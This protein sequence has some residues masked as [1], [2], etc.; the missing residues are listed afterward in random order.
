MAVDIGPKI[1][2]DGEAEFRREI[3]NITQQIKTFGSELNAVTAEFGANERSVQG[4]TAKNEILNKSI[5]AQERKVRE[6]KKGLEAA[7]KEFGI[8]DTK[9]LKWAQAVNNATADLNKMRNQVKKNDTEIDKL[10]DSVKQSDTAMDDA[11]KSAIGFGDILKGSVAADLITSALSKIADSIH[12][13]GQALLDFSQEQENALKKAT[14]YFGETG[15]AA[16]QTEKVIKDVFAGGVGDS[17]DA[18][19]NA[20]VTVKKNL[21]D[22]SETDLK[23]L[24]NQAITLDSLY[25]IDM[26]ETLR[27]VNGLMEQ[28]GMDAQT[29]MDF[30]VTGTQNGLDKT[31]ELG[32]NLAEYSGKFA[33]AGYSAEEYF[34]LLNNGLDGG[35]YN[36]D[37]VNDAIN[38]VTTRLADGTIEDSMK[39]YSTETRKLFKEWKKGEATQKQVIDSIVNDIKGTEN[40]QE[41]LNK[42]AKAFGTM[43]EDGN[44][45]FITS[46]SSIGDSYDQVGGKAQEM[47]NATTTNQQKITASMRT[48]QQ[49]LLPIGDALSGVMVEVAESIMQLV[50]GMDFEG[51]AASITE[52]FGGFLE[53]FKGIT[54]GSMS[55]SEGFN[56][57]YQSLTDVLAGILTSIAQALP[58]MIKSGLE[59]IASIT[60]GIYSNAP[61]LL[62]Q[63]GQIMQEVITSIFDNMPGIL[64]AGVEIVL[65]LVNGLIAT[66]PDLLVQAAQLVMDLLAEI[67][68]H[69]PELLESG[70]E[71]VGQL[72][73][74]LIK[75]IPDLIAAIPDVIVGITDTLLKYD[76]IQIGKDIL[77]GLANG[78]LGFVGTVVD[79]AKEAAGKIAD[80]FKDFFDIHS[81]SRLMKDE[82]GRQIT[83]GIA[84]G[85]LADKKYATKSAEEVSSAILSAAQKKLDNHKTYNTL[86]LADE[87]AFWDEMRMKVKEGTQARIEAD[88]KYFAAKKSLDSKILSHEKSY[89]DSVSKVYKELNNNI[90]E[91]WQ[92]YHD[93]VDSLAESIRS[94]MGLF[95]RFEVKTELN[96]GDLLDNLKSQVE[97]LTNWRESLDRLEGRGIPKGLLEELESMGTSAAGEVAQLTKMTDQELQEYASLWG[98][99][100]ALAREAAEEQLEPLLASTKKQIGQLRYE[101]RNELEAYQEEYV[102]AM[103]EIG[104]SLVQPLEGVKNALIT[105]FVDI[106]GTLADTVDNQSGTEENKGKYEQIAENIIK[107][108][109]GLPEDFEK[110]GED[111]ISGI[112][113]GLSNRSSELYQAMSAIM[114]ETIGAAQSTAQIHSPSRVMRDLIG[115]NMITG[116]ADGL[117]EYGRMAMEAATQVTG[118]VMGSFAGANVPVSANGTAAAYNR[119][120]ASIENMQIVMSDGTLV[121]KISPRIDTTLGGYA[122]VK[123]RYNT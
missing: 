46:L 91:A 4:L 56:T 39:S 16:E 6:L 13:V 23:N 94:Q 81:P 84:E 20:V 109:D 72:I 7:T 102:A 67:G 21:D 50:Q 30:I 66:A 27:G 113:Q 121:G 77:T 83:A 9:T 12:E 22:L 45:K 53:I 96:T 63:M 64:E 62:E 82:V 119:L 88:K 59:I 123:R 104:A 17:M 114:K 118:N 98:T 34:Q 51:F 108:A 87:A 19:A 74:G 33:Q 89:K 115:K 24:T 112:I 48:M 110:I 79:A 14:A 76:W 95:D 10:T 8:S 57:I 97:G 52:L 35:A 117:T 36:L 28:F 120:A 103:Q 80:A 73:A 1:G 55:A 106:I 116:L 18:V 2:I 32:D 37:K 111:T 78:I 31:N 86:T 3:N 49:Q 71:L 40:Q 100:N 107:S 11:G 42:A 93:E 54:N 90:R 75:A 58:K 25:G 43:A 70:I 60:E 5:E 101:A 44:L 68:A 26:N 69:L 41:A 61:V 122:K 47:F 38:E 99:K 15:A 29:A 105:N 65:N 85:I 92:S